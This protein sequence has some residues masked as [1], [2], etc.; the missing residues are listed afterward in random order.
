VADTANF[1][2]DATVAFSQSTDPGTYST[3]KIRKILSG[4]QIELY[5][6]LTGFT[7]TFPAKIKQSNASR[8]RTL[9]NLIRVG[10]EWWFFVTAWGIF[11]AE[12]PTYV[13]LLEETH[14]FTH[15]GV[16]PSS[17]TA[18]I[19]YQPSPV[20]WRGFNSDTISHEN[21]TILNGPVTDDPVT[22]VLD[23]PT[24]PKY[25]LAGRSTV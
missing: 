8:N 23:Y 9:R 15:S 17:A 12:S 18:V 21:M 24:F 19:Q 5:H 1:V 7:T 22:G 4:T 13:A 16:G 6:G 11:D 3:S 25:L 14:L 2:K 10:D 20:A